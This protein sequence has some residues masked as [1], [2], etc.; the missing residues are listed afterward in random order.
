MQ[1]SYNSNGFN[2]AQ[3]HALQNRLT[4][5]ETA[6]TRYFTHEKVENRNKK[7]RVKYILKI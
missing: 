3:N 6:T 2:D 7:Q 4:D 1:V 5:H